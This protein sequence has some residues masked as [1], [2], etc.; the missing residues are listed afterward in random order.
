MPRRELCLLRL[1]ELG[2]RLAGP[3]LGGEQAIAQRRQ[4]LRRRRE[5]DLRQDAEQPLTASAEPGV[6]KPNRTEAASRAAARRDTIVMSNPRY[7]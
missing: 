5:R 4:Q 1:G 3:H 6:G 7:T 2:H